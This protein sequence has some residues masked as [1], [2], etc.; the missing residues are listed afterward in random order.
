M[1]VRRVSYWGLAG[2]GE[3]QSLPQRQPAHGQ[4]K[5]REKERVT[6]KGEVL[7][8]F[9]TTKYGNAKRT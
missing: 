5:G 9:E 4:F 7:S 3:L 2:L 1:S 6:G 8:C